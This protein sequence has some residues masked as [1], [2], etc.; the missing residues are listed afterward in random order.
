M[1]T[2]QLLAQCGQRAVEVLEA[3][4]DRAMSSPGQF[5][6]KASVEDRKLL[7]AMAVRSLSGA[8]CAE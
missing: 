8:F 3:E 5:I 2:G 7:N 6:S 4:T 1:E